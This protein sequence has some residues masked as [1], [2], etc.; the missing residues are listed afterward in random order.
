V[1]IPRHAQTH[2]FLQEVLTIERFSATG[3]DC[4]GIALAL[5][6]YSS[7]RRVA[8][9]DVALRGTGARGGLII[10]NRDIRAMVESIRPPSA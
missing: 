8:M 10:E 9:V 6:T 7:L 4:P 5:L 1:T 2:L 3:R